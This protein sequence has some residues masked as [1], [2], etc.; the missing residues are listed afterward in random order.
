MMICCRIFVLCNA[1]ML[2]SILRWTKRTMKRSASRK[3]LT[4]WQSD[5]KSSKMIINVAGKATTSYRRLFLTYFWSIIMKFLSYRKSSGVLWSQI[6]DMEKAIS[7]EEESLKIK[8]YTLNDKC[9]LFIFHR[10]SGKS[11]RNWLVSLPR[12]V[13]WMKRLWTQFHTCRRTERFWIWWT[14]IA[15][16]FIHWRRNQIRLPK[17]SKCWRLKVFWILLRYYNCKC[18][19]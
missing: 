4:A 7:V 6:N 11:G 15:K 10:Y 19:I 17:K 5:T 18:M 12:N 3:R 9:E 1:K 14:R 8:Q 16:N 13:P 2:F